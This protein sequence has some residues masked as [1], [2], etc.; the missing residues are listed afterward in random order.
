MV[1]NNKVVAS[2][3]LDTGKI[4]HPQEGSTFS[5]GGSDM[6]ASRSGKEVKKV[7]EIKVRRIRIRN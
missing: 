7:W 5:R 6:A 2:G 3:R 4:S 1:V